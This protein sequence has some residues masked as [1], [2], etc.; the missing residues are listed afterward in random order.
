MTEKSYGVGPVQ[1]VE[2]RRDER[3]C[4]MRESNERQAEIYRSQKM[5]FS[6]KKKREKR[7]RMIPF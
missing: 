7:V 3:E 6:Y 5:Y 1:G 2:N 4:R